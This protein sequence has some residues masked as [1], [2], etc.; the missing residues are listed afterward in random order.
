MLNLRL[1]VKDVTERK[2]LTSG[3]FLNFL[4]SS[5]EALWVF[6]PLLGSELDSNTFLTYFK[7]KD[8]VLLFLEDCREFLATRVRGSMWSVELY[9][10]RA[11]TQEFLSTAGNKLL[12]LTESYD[13]IDDRF[14]T[15]FPIKKKAK[16]TSFI[17]ITNELKSNHS[18]MIVQQAHDC[19]LKDLDNKISIEDFLSSVRK[20]QVQF[21]GW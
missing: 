7:K 9:G 1:C 12:Q 13:D 15:S 8:F 16:V 4:K 19:T 21:P 14:G 6:L 11:L 20:N 17:D 5:K 2:A 10:Y 18:Y 3:M